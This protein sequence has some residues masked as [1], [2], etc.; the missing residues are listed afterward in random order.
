MGHSF[1]ITRIYARSDSFFTFSFQEICSLNAY[2]YL[3]CSRRKGTCGTSV[4]KQTRA[5]DGLKQL[6]NIHSSVAINRV[7]TQTGFCKGNVRLKSDFK[8][9]NI[10]NNIASGPSLDSFIAQTQF[11]GGNANI[12][13][14]EAQTQSEDAAP[15]LPASALSGA[16]RKVYFETYGCQMNVSDTEVAWSILQSHGFQKTSEPKLAD[17]V[18][19]MTCAIRENAEQRIWNRLEYFG[20]LK[21]KRGNSKNP[22][23]IG[24]LGCMAERLKKKIVEKTKAVDVVAG[25]DAYRD[26]PRLLSVADSGQT[27]INVMLSVDETY[28][29]V[30]PVRLDKA[31][32]TAF[33]SIMRGCDNMCSYC[34][35]PFTR[36]RERSRPLSSILEEIKGLSDQGAREV[37]LLG[38]NVNS[39]RDVSEETYY[40]YGTPESEDTNLA[41]GF[42]TIYKSKKGGLRFAHLL[43]RVAQVNPEMRIRFTSP[44]PKDF[45]DEVL[46]TVKDYNN[47]CNQLHLPA[48]SGN[49]DVLQRMRRGYT[50]ESYLQFVDHVRTIVP[51]VSI[52]SDF[53]A[54]F[55]G[56]TESEHQ[57]TLSLLR[58]VRYNYAYLFAY[59]MRQKTHA[60]HRMEDD[61]TDEI[62]NRRLNEIIGV[63]RQNVQEI[64]Q[65]QIGQIQLVL[66]E[67]PSKRD[68]NQMV[69]KNDGGTR[70][71]LS[72]IESAGAST[73]D[74]HENHLKPG[75]YVA[76]EIT[77][78][79]SQVLKGQVLF[80][81][82][83]QKFPLDLQSWKDDRISEQARS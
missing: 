63:F 15:Y 81:T 5:S 67:G 76:V 74:V 28:A 77:A 65:Q 47:I 20:S 2:P 64:N 69:G 56:E 45:P 70:V 62:K 33:V 37:T 51:G 25:P 8:V 38:Q 83:L 17:V 29:D 40:G 3:V 13:K 73:G 36:G 14:K 68:P 44:H 11:Q 21:R 9:R 27:A 16:D 57:D 23:K 53:I 39:Y 42:E 59:S 49:S 46:H 58:L 22:L 24:L 18:L 31:S 50:R 32:K 1:N 80:P 78:A 12:Q 41:E 30:V 66:V 71:I 72:N 79:T 48:Q 55:C 82:K 75:D 19:L 61:V 10:R 6:H 35:V 7:Y 26:L 43:E 4:I 52:S 54:G 60:Y 34:I